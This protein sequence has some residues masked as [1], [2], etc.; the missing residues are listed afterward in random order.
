MPAR[1]IFL[2]LLSRV[3]ILILVLAA[4][5]CSGPFAH[6]RQGMP[7]LPKGAQALPPWVAPS[8]EQLLVVVPE[9]SGSSLAYLY[10]LERG[11]GGW[12]AMAGPLDA[13]LG[14]NG[15]AKPGRK[16]EGDGHTPSGMF[17]L[18]FAFGYASTIVTRMPYRQATIDDLW[19]DDAGSPEYNQ[20][21]RRGRTGAKSFE[22]LRL[23]DH[24]YRHGL[25]IGYNR[26]PATP[27]LGSAIFIHVWRETGA[28]TTGCVAMAEA[29]LV[30]LLAW[31]DPAK[32]PAILMGDPA[33]L[34]DIP[35]L[36]GFAVPTSSGIQ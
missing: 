5:A 18:E 11:T 22:E 21:V 8:S 10:A 28:S 33:D 9:K 7:V 16:R 26:N 3:L 14:D 12:T 23:P 34:S 24:R 19:V 4:A 25:V 2:P 36:A 30:T 1:G 29:D 17:P 13:T 20:W 6:A 35:G 15:F 31:L 27:G 32:K